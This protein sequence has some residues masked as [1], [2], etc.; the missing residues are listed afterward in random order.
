MKLWFITVITL[1]RGQVILHLVC[2]RDPCHLWASPNLIVRSQSC[3]EVTC[4]IRW[5]GLTEDG[6][7]VNQ[8]VI[9]YRLWWAL[10]Q[11]FLC[12]LFSD[13]IC[14]T[15]EIWNTLWRPATSRL[16]PSYVDN[17]QPQGT[18]IELLLPPCFVMVSVTFDA[19]IFGL[20]D[21]VSGDQLH[22]QSDHYKSTA[23]MRT[24]TK[25]HNVPLP[26]HLLHCPWALEITGQSQESN[27]CLQMSKPYCNS[28]WGTKPRPSRSST[29][30]KNKQ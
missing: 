25:H 26:W 27:W 14:R 9:S 10:Q 30:P 28:T 12:D 22:H 23:L 11:G 2:S 16:L 17:Q 18:I 20:F 3:A 8:L 6:A 7:Y 1:D 29:D 24:Y 5:N 15:S 4:L 19:V 21:F 13:D